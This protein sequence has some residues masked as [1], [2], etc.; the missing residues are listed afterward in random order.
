MTTYEHY[1]SQATRAFDKLRDEEPHDPNKI[2][3]INLEE[4]RTMAFI[5]AAENFERIANAL[6]KANEPVKVASPENV[7]PIKKDFPR[8]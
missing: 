1:R 8:V 4:A 6:E 7:E 5:R 3:L 2:M